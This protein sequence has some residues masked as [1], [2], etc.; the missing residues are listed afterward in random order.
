MQPLKVLIDRLSSYRS[1]HISILDLSGILHL[2]ATE[3]PFENSIHSKRFCDIAKSTARGYRACLYCKQCATDKA[4]C[5]KEAFHGSCFFGVYEA[6]FPVIIQ[7]SVV[8]VVYVGNAVCDMQQTRARL[9]KACRCT[10]VSEQELLYALEQSEAVAD[11]LELLQIGEIVA[12]YLKALCKNTLPQIKAEQ[13]W[14]V[15]L[16]RQ[17]AEQQLCSPISLKEIATL[18]RKNE[19]YVG[20]LFKKETGKSFAEYCNDL[21]QERA[22]QLISQGAGSVISVAMECGFNN[23]SYFN[24]LFRKKYGVSPTAYKKEE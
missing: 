21:R 2:K 1:I 12:D 6:V 4:V 19:K 3:L 7:E 22:A 16:M 13:H 11:P 10:G 24:R 8:A 14:I 5:G 15:T 23:I 17:Y 18:Y 9:Q 20:R